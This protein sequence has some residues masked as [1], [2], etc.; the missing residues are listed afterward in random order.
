MTKRRYQITI[1]VDTRLPVQEFKSRIKGWI[2]D[3]WW[4]SIGEIVYLAN[5]RM[6]TAAVKDEPEPKA[7][8]TVPKP[9]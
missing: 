1:Q 8:A 9:E 6:T 2:D 5:E 4:K 7:K 3:N